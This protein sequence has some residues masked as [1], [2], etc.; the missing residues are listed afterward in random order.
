MN[1]RTALMLIGVLALVP[2]AAFTQPKDN[3]EITFSQIILSENTDKP[4]VVIKRKSGPDIEITVA[5][6]IEGLQNNAK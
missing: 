2:K 1:R 4:I 6:I 5:D 3:D